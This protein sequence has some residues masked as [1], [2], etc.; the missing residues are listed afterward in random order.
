M[1]IKMKSTYDPEDYS[2]SPREAKMILQY[3]E[4]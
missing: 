3:Y 1:S 4:I 2:E